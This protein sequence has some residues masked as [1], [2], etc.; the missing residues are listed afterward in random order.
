MALR[1]VGPADPPVIGTYAMQAPTSTRLLAYRESGN[2]DELARVLGFG[3]GPQW[4]SSA[5]HDGSVAALLQIIEMDLRSG[6]ASISVQIAPSLQGD[7]VA[8][9]VVADDLDE[10]LSRCSL[11]YPFRRLY[12]KLLA[13]WVPRLQAL[14]PPA[15]FEE[16]RLVEH[17]FID[18]DYSDLI[19]YSM[20]TGYASTPDD[21]L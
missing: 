2:P 17:Q 12:W 14:M 11:S 1:P 3:V 6:V 8:T 10:F 19:I 20:T 4:I 7:P 9:A 21:V 16:A 13:C 18:G 15:M 5:P